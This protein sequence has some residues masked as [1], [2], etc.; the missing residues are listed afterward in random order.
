MPSYASASSTRPTLTTAIS[1]PPPLLP[2]FPTLAASGVPPL[3]TPP[4]AGGEGEGGR[5]EED[6]VNRSRERRQRRLEDQRPPVELLVAVKPRRLTPTA[7]SASSVRRSVFFFHAG[8]PAQPLIT[9][10]CTSAR[11]HQCEDMLPCSLVDALAFELRGNAVVHH[12]AHR[13]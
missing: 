2:E 10:A 7:S 1:R 4:H 12:H 13:W 6:R 5:G 9:K 3:S 11:G 8:H